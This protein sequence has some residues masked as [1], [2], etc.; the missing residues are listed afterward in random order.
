MQCYAKAS[1]YRIKIVPFNMLIDQEKN[2]QK[3][4]TIPRYKRARKTEN[5]TN[6]III[7]NG[8]S[9]KI[10]KNGLEMVLGRENKLYSN[11]Y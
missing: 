11:T 3:I 7:T 4:Q 2:K 1:V 10:A 8:K 9:R 6:K 5:Q